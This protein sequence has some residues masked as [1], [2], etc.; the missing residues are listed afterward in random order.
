MALLGLPPKDKKSTG[1]GSMSLLMAVPGIM[2]VA[3]LMGFFIGRWVDSKFDT[4]PY[5]TVVGLALGFGAAAREIYS[6]V[7]KAQAL[8]EKE[9]D[10]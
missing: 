2:L 5:L 9:D 6:L 1:L 10:S 3:P 7:K 8:E 4:D